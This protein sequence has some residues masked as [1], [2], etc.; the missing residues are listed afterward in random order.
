[1]GSAL[2]S[3]AKRPFKVSSKER[4]WLVLTLVDFSVPE[5]YFLTE[6]DTFARQFLLELVF[7]PN[8]QSRKASENRQTKVIL[9]GLAALD[10]GVNNCIQSQ[11]VGHKGPLHEA[12]INTKTSKD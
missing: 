3:T 11:P 7:V 2:L 10:K 9:G 6:V 1:M 8:D 4:L 12:L 5:R